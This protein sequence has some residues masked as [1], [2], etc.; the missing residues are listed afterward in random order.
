MFEGMYKAFGRPFFVEPASAQ[1]VNNVFQDEYQI[2]E[3]AKHNVRSII[4]FGAHVGS[5]SV[6]CHELWPKA[7]IMAVEPHPESYELLR[8]NTDHIPQ[9]TPSRDGLF[10][11]CNCAI[12][13]S[14]GTFMMSSPVSHSRVSEY[15]GSVWDGIGK[16]RH[17]DFGIQVHGIT[18]DTFWEVEV[19]EFFDNDEIDL[20][21]LDCEGAE[22]LIL[23][24]LARMG[25]MNRIGWIRGE[26]HD[27]DSNV[28][29]EKSLSDTHVYNIDPN[30]PHEVGLFIAHRKESVRP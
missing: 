6:L 23:P 16:P 9:R 30:R 24:G 20:I 12:T 15:V 17:S 7:K 22:Y 3:L 29:L 11:A 14:S 27:W 18:I 10:R 26:W 4:D 8:R 2:K 25:V 19:Q 5:F 21:K 13:A 1:F 28:L